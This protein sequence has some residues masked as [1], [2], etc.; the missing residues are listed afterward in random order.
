VLHRRRHIRQHITLEHGKIPGLVEEQKS[1]ELSNMLG[2]AFAEAENVSKVEYEAPEEVFEEDVAPVFI[3]VE[4]EG[5]E[6]SVLHNAPDEDLLLELAS[7]KVSGL[8]PEQMVSEILLLTE[9]FGL[10]SIKL[11]PVLQL[12]VRHCQS[13][14]YFRKTGGLS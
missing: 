3:H 5:I 1:D 10:S 14:S 4:R 12:A 6:A 11:I 7:R 13:S 8:T 2:D 9:R